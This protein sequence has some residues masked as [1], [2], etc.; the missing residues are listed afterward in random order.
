MGG[1][2]IAAAGFVLLALPGTSGSYWTT[3]FPGVAVLGLGMAITVAP[4][5]TTVMTAAGPERAGL[6]SGVN[7]AVSRTASLLAIAVFGIV[8][9]VRF[10][11]SLSQRLDTLGVSPEIRRLILDQRRKLAA[12]T[13]PDSVAGSLKNTLR[14]GIASSFVD[15]FRWIMVIAAGLAV[16]SAAIA[17]ALIGTR[18]SEST[19]PSK[20]RARSSGAGHPR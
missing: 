5:T 7:N 1:P 10:S 18:T 15:G 14:T 9:Y 2:L 11:Q 19:A 6:A 13:I 12:A 20:P 16:A 17:W 3:F 8:A 4:L